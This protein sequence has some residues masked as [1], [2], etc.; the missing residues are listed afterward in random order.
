MVHG[1][2]IRGGVGFGVGLGPWLPCLS[3]STLQ[4]PFEEG[5][6]AVMS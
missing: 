3:N 1:T 5:N 6:I 2:Q 4:L